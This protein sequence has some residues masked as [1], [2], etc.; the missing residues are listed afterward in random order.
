MWPRCCEAGA[1][2]QACMRM[3]HRDN[4][5]SRAIAPEHGLGVKQPVVLPPK[6][7]PPS[8]MPG[9]PTCRTTKRRLIVEAI[10]PM[11][12][13]V[14]HERVSAERASAANSKVR[15]CTEN[16]LGPT[17]QVLPW[18]ILPECQR[19]FRGSCP[20]V[21]L[22]VAALIGSDLHMVRALHTDGIGTV[23]NS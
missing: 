9:G 5:R 13:A 8:R 20:I 12:H 11:Q 3:L 18:A 19:N 6:P 15:T 7:L 4:G 10:P 21:S 2:T 22:A 17:C 23:D 16:R 1:T 14:D